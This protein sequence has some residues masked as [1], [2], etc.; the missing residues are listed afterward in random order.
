MHPEVIAV[1]RSRFDTGHFADAVEAA[2]KHFNA[3]VKKLAGSGIASDLD[4]APLM[5][6]VFSP[7]KP[8][9]KLSDLSTATGK[10]IQNGY[11]QMFAGAM[12]GIRNPKAHENITIDANRATHLLFVARLFFYKLAE[13]TSDGAV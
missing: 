5:N 6:K 4:G 7:N 13:T 9:I 12:T 11:M 8:I 2:F 10:N 3:T 1:A